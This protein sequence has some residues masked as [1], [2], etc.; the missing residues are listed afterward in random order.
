MEMD[1]TAKMPAAVR[2]TRWLRFSR[3]PWSEGFRLASALRWRVVTQ[4]FYRWQFAALGPG[5][6]IRR[7]IMLAGTQFIK[8]GAR[9]QIRD[10]VRLEAMQT[11]EKRTPFLQIGDD[12]NIEQF[13]HIVCHSRLTI[14]P[15]VSIAGHSAI[16]DVTHPYDDM[17][18]LAKIGDAILDED[19]FVEIGEGSL[20]GFGVVVLPNV[21]IGK[22]CVIGANSVV[23]R[24]IP[25]YTIAAGAPA[26][27]VRRYD[28]ERALWVPITR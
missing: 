10:G 16:L 9:V 5:S 13:V 28:S 15:R 14:G 4:M 2:K 11:N 18:P 6:T 3:A 26:K 7:P 25:D 24:S 12:T 22:H 1:E 27:P 20:L 19:S 21:R 8:L 23:T 17:S